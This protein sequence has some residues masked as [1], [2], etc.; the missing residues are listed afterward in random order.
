MPY[1]TLNISNSTK[2]PQLII[3]RY[4]VNDLEEE[5]ILKGFQGITINTLKLLLL[6]YA[7][8]I[9]IFAESEVELQ[10]GLN[11]LKQYCQTWKLVVN[12]NKTK[13]MVFRKGGD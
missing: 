1:C 9:V 11:I 6:L 5:F 7:D 3:Y 4:Y 13:V 12:V 2:R 8:D 10:N